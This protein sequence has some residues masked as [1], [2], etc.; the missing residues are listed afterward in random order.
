MNLS[1]SFDVLVVIVSV[2]L[3]M[4]DVKILQDFLIPW[5]TVHY[6]TTQVIF[7]Q[8]F[9]QIHGSRTVQTTCSR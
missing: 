2:I 1:L 4:S 8:D 5:I 9:A 3:G 6:D 7:V